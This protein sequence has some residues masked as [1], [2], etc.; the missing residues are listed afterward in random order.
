MEVQ[1]LLNQDKIQLVIQVAIM[2]Y[3][4]GATQQEIANKLK[5]AR[6]TVSKLLSLAKKFGIV[7]IKIINPLEDLK[8]IGNALVE[9]YNLKNAAVVPGNFD[10]DILRSVLTQRA[11]RYILEKIGNGNV[12]I[13]I[14]WGRTVFNVVEYMD[15]VECE[16]INIFPLIGASTKTAPYYMVNEM[17]RN[18]CD[19]LSA[20]SIYAYVPANPESKK[21]AKLF[22]NTSTYKAIKTHWE[23]VDIAI[24]G[25]GRSPVENSSNREKY[26][27]EN[28][29]TIKNEITG[30]ILT[31]YFDLNG[32]FIQDDNIEMLCATVEELRKAKCVI[33]IAG[34][35]TKMSAILGA[36]NTGVITDLI[37]D[38]PTAKAILKLN[39]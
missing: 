26:P 14:S 16:N 10:D 39:N 36:L 28:N 29:F 20:T 19:K 8:R 17:V 6:Q 12:N 15:T 27:G 18:L 9:K 24:L 33:A 22:K 1:V 5:L 30:D 37:I 3:K 32:N 13:G 25:I 34:G 2:Y 31:H 4:D 11:C 21:D 35:N 23:N 38:G 7:E